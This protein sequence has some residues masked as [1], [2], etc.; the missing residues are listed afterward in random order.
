MKENTGSA[1][2]PAGS[3]APA[4]RTQVLDNQPRCWQP[5]IPARPAGGVAAGRGDSW[6]FGGAMKAWRD[7][8]EPEAGTAAVGR[9]GLQGALFLQATAASV[10]SWSLK[11]I[12]LAKDWMKYE[13]RGSLK[14][15]LTNGALNLW[16]YIYIYFYTC[17]APALSK[18]TQLHVI[19]D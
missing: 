16:L 7:E 2:G 5:F 10:S 12:H 9:L 13:I 6:S 3:G 8:E 15:K 11:T 1:Q 19:S 4:L 17:A 18:K 14:Q